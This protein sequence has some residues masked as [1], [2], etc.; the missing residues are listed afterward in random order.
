MTNQE[1]IIQKVKDVYKQYECNCG[2][3]LYQSARFE[4]VSTQ[5]QM[6]IKIAEIIYE[7]KDF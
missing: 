2:E 4:D 6:L 3:D 1:H 5:N 7:T